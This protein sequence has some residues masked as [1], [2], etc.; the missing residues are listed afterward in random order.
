[1]TRILSQEGEDTKVSG[2]FFKSVVE[3]VLLLG[4]E[5][6]VLTPQTERALSSFHHRVVQWLTRRNPNRKGKGRWEYPPLVTAMEEAGF[7]DI[8]VYIT[9]RKNTASQYIATRPIMEL[10]E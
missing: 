6:W 3:A 9:R 1:M 4:T 5:M 7:E 2:L 10:C 8:R